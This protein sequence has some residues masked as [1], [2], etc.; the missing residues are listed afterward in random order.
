MESKLVACTAIWNGSWKI[1]V[2][3]EDGYV[4]ETFRRAL[5]SGIAVYAEN[6]NL[7]KKFGHK[8]NS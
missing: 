8:E 3:L 4:R 1:F 7:A 5:L 2:T 6:W